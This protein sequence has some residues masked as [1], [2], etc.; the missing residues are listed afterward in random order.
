MKAKDVMTRSVIHTH[1][2]T[3]TAEVAALLSRHR[4]SA[5]PITDDH[6]TV[7]GLVS[8]FDLLSKRGKTAGE[9]MSPGVISVTEETDVEDVRYLLVER[10]IKRVPVLAGQQLVG[11]I[12]RSDIVRLMVLEWICQ[13][14][15]EPVRGESPPEHC[16]RCAAPQT[17][18]VQQAPP[19]GD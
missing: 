3:P 19:P 7:V 8:E 18:F 5:V 14:C 12:S 9:I 16:P 13:V 6:G 11:I 17:C 10:R 4:I 2:G 15:G 1:L